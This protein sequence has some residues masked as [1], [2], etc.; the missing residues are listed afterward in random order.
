MVVT[1]RL[2]NGNQFS[3]SKKI[4]FF[5]K[6]E[7]IRAM[8]NREP[9]RYKLSVQVH[10][11]FSESFLS[12]L[13]RFPSSRPFV[14]WLMPRCFTYAWGIFVGTWYIP[15]YSWYYASTWHVFRQKITMVTSR[16]DGYT[17]G[18]GG[19]QNLAIV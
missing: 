13:N 3:S 11:Y 1:L 8:W 5:Y 9:I 7:P 19:F 10:R 6:R 16:R 17:C 15:G 18:L 2:R 4:F 14:T 12:N